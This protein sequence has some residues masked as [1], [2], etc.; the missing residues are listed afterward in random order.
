MFQGRLAL[1]VQVTKFLG[2]KDDAGVVGGKLA[3]GVMS[4]VT[5]L[6]AS[7]SELID[8][9]GWDDNLTIPLLSSMGMYGVLKVFG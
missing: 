8:L 5:G 6:I 7:C 4:V 1:P 3:L 2:W 9:F